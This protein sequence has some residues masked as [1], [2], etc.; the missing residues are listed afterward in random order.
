MDIGIPPTVEQ[1]NALVRL[2]NLQNVTVFREDA[3]HWHIYQR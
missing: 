1:R 2:Y 3:A